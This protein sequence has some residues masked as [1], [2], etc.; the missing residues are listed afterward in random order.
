MQLAQTL[1]SEFYKTR[2]GGTKDT[3]AL[4]SLLGAGVLTAPPIAALA[5]PAFAGALALLGAGYFTR[6]FLTP[7]SEKN[8]LPS[9]IEAMSDHSPHVI[10]GKWDGFLMGYT[11]DT[12]E[13]VYVDDTNALRHMLMVGM[14]GVGKTV[15]GMLFMFQQIMRGG[16]LLFVDGKLD[17]DNLKTLW[18]YCQMAGRPQDFRVINPG[19]PR[20]S[21]TYNPILYGDPDEVASRILSLIPSTE[22]NPGADHYKQEANQGVATLVAALQKA[23]LAYNMI[24][25][26]IL[27]MSAAA[28]LELEKKLA[29]SET[30]RDSDE[31]KNY[32]LFLD[33]FRAPDPRT[34]VVS[35]NISKLKDTFG[36]IGGRLYMFGTGNFGQVMNTYDPDVRLYEAIMQRQVIYVALPTMGKSEAASNFGKMVMGDLRTAI[37]WIQALAEKDRPDPP[38]F[39]FLDEL[40]SYATASLAR[41][42]EQARS[43]RII[44]CGALQTYANL[45]SVSEEF[46]QMVLGNTWTKIYFKL[47]EQ[48]TALAAAEQIGQKIGILRSLSDTISTSQTASF[49]RA[50]PESSNA[51]ATGVSI[52]EREQEEYQISPDDLKKLDKGEI[53]AT[54]GGDLKF[55]LRVPFIRISDEA[56]AAF[57][58]VHLTHG[59][60]KESRDGAG[61]ALNP[62]RFLQTVNAVAS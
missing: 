11:T 46:R 32:T 57:G 10:G 44:L 29:H 25:V 37:S 28:L 1:I 2:I 26:S 22:N 40:G 4:M 48:D 31:L 42:F 12:G 34:G 20:N 8:I 56:A 19:D 49:L 3:V 52:G 39:C 14:T 62:A 13:P 5:P 43:A 38:F 60:R 54:Y 41:P 61:F 24:D 17:S 30:G 27:L 16:G 7:V 35:I 47:G 6:K 45:E 51:D 33:K 59:H 21:H 53:I 15:L 23:G 55:N 58:P 36:G 9:N 18:G 50:T